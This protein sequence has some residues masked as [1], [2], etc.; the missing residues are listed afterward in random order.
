MD[1]NYIA[2]DG[3]LYFCTVDITKI[4]NLTANLNFY[5]GT[6]DDSRV[7]ADQSTTSHRKVVFLSARH[8]LRAL[9]RQ[10]QLHSNKH[11]PQLIGIVSLIAQ[12]YYSSP[13]QELFAR[14]S[15]PYEYDSTAKPAVAVDPEKDIQTCVSLLT[16]LQI[17]LRTI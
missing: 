7:I 15:H 6:P 10:R 14:G 12:E 3:V 4:L 13:N 11:I 8:M 5:T 9:E 2:K 17:H 16:A 1:I